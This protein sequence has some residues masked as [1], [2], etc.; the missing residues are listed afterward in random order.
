[1]A[2]P[3]AYVC[4]WCEHLASRHLAHPG[5]VTVEGPYDCTYDGCQCK[6]WQTHAIYGIDEAT[7]NRLHLPQLDHYRHAS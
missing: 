2:K 6:L 3:F 5:S 4:S 1:M 7:F